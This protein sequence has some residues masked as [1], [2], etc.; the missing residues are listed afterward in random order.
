MIAGK[1]DTD[2]HKA[3]HKVEAGIGNC[4]AQGSQSVEGEN[5]WLDQSLVVAEGTIGLVV[6]AKGMA[7]VVEIAGQ[8]KVGIAAAVVVGKEHRKAG[9]TDVEGTEGVVAEKDSEESQVVDKI[10][11]GSWV[12]RQV[13][14][15]VAVSTVPVASKVESDRAEA[16]HHAASPTAA[17]TAGSGHWATD[18][19]S[20]EARRV[21]AAGVDSTKEALGAQGGPVAHSE[22][23]AC[24]GD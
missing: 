23:Q 18:S 12:D 14:R 11:V 22:R 3:E 6:A 13:D 19:D 17:G 4:S 20:A 16:I 21:G 2:N 10:G 8:D 24:K 9:R 15:T 1:A 5:S 7:G